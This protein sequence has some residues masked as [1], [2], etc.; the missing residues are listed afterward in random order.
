MK[1]VYKKVNH[2]PDTVVPSTN[3]LE[4]SFFARLF[5]FYNEF[6]DWLFIDQLAI[7]AEV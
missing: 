2:F 7:N 1:N 4:S 3:P 5:N 6:F